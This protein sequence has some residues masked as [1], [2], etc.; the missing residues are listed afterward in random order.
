MIRTTLS[1]ALPALVTLLFYTSAP[2]LAAAKADPRLDGSWQIDTVASD[3]FDAKLQRMAEE[4]RAKRRNR[5]G[6]PGGGGPGGAG[7]YEP[8]TVPG[9]ADELPPESRDELGDRL[10]ETF[11]PPS[12]LHIETHGD[13]I[14]M[15][16]DAPPERRFR[17][18]ET[19][20]RMDTSG[21]STIS[22]RWSA[23]TLLV[24][25]RY[26]NRSR[27]QVRYG[28]DRTGALLNVTLQLSDTIG[29]KLE[30]HSTYRRSAP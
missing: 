6:A 16:G 19:V 25:S 9:L 12:R 26:T 13:E 28:V 15:R 10:G 23:A 3:N 18:L 7:G 14:V 22:T 17:L 30:L 11:R 4:L 29:G 5:R 21:T 2:T 1:W 24:E 27:S 8:G 20:T